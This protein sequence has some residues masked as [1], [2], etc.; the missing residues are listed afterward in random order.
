MWTM[1][2]AVT[3]SVATCLNVAAFV[4]VASSVSAIMRAS[5]MKATQVG[6]RS[7]ST[8]PPL[9]RILRYHR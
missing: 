6:A 8:P 2:F 9:R 5:K 3:L 7:H 1:I 4:I